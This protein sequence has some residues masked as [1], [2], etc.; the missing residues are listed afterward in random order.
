[1]EEIRL[2]IEHLT[3]TMGLSGSLMRISAD[4][5]L[6]AMSLFVAWL[7]F[8]VC[9]RVLVPIL[10][11]ITKKTDIAWD[12]ILLNQKTLRAA[13]MI[14]PA[15]VIW[16]CIPH[17]FYRHP[18]FEELL[19]RAT[20]VYITITSMQLFLAFIN[21]FKDLEGDK[22]TA[23]Q[24]YFHTFCGVMK[25]I[26]IFISVIVMAAIVI[27]RSPLTLFAGLGAT[28]AVLMLVFKDTISGLVAGVRLTSNDMLQKGDWIT[29]EK[30][31]V[32]GIV[33][34]ITLTTVKV[35]NFDNTIVTI[36]PQTLVEDTFQNWKSMQEG[37]GRR[38]TRRIYFDFTTIRLADDRLKQHL[39]AKGYLTADEMRDDEV[40]LTLFRRFVEKY[41]ASR[42]DV[43]P[44]MLF[45]VREFEPT[46]TG[47]PVEFYFFV[48]NKEWKSYEH[49][50]AEIMEHIYAFVPEFGLAIYQRV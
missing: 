30:A 17:I 40:N 43:N 11:K 46:S 42:D 38:V 27:G 10:V 4:V 22:R 29:V 23:R 49:H 35:R 1:M 3:A 44:D 32:N 18:D 45:M 36:T 47:L 9:H 6:V 33:E 15:I 48:R 25:I 8:V 16:S 50:A 2:I 14:V 21:S 41:L 20:A 5:V 39:A 34:D 7:S 26:V 31:G 19:E 13:C 24:Q 12:D 37:G 28:S